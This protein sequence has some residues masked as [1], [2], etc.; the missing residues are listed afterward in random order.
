MRAIILFNYDVIQYLYLAVW[1]SNIP[2]TYG[3][4]EEKRHSQNEERDTKLYE[5][6]FSS[7]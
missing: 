3:T 1:E 7:V 2:I 6:N 5:N 4:K